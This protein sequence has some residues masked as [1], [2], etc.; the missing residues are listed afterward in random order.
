MAFHTRNRSNDT[1]ESSAE[2]K[3]CFNAHFQYR[4]SKITG[5]KLRT[6]LNTVCVNTKESFSWNFLNSL[7][8]CEN[9]MSQTL[10]SRHFV[11]LF[12]GCINI[13]GNPFRNKY[14]T[15]KEKYLKFIFVNSSNENCV[16]HRRVYSIFGLRIYSSFITSS[17]RAG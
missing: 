6:H 7:M 16:Q 5:L 13:S 17:V 8:L 14:V 1:T 10:C 4:Q 2:K 12:C 11:L 15:F 9:H 3:S